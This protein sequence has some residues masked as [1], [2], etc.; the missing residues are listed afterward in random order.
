M[1]QT[2]A[3]RGIPSHPI[4]SAAPE[5]GTPELSEAQVYNSQRLAGSGRSLGRKAPSVRGGEW[6]GGEQMGERE[7][8]LVSAEGSRNST[9]LSVCALEIPNHCSPSY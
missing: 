8:A 3:E 5:A 6:A 1:R 4:P 9:K 2:Y 7:K